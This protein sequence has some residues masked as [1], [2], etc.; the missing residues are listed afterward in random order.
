M[1]S[2]PV[3]SIAHIP[4]KGKRKIYGYLS[5]LPRR[6]DAYFTTFEEYYDG[7]GGIICVQPSAI[8]MGIIILAGI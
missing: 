4:I 2:N 7:I 3:L 8:G 6:K 1:F 5:I